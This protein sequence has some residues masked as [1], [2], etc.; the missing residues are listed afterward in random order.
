M[1]QSH[2]EP[3]NSE[4][5][6]VPPLFLDITIRGPRYQGHILQLRA[7]SIAVFLINTKLPS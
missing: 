4:T 6:Y 2:T 5:M 1:G 7:F 3:S